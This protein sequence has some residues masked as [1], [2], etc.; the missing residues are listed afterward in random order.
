MAHFRFVFYGFSFGASNFANSS[1]GTRIIKRQMPKDQK[2]Y[3]EQTKCNG[4]GCDK[5]NTCA[6]YKT[7]KDAARELIKAPRNCTQ[8]KTQRDV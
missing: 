6:L 7:K 3:T 1:E 8:Y 2:K 5:K 4:A